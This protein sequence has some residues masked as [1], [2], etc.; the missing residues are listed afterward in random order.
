MENNLEANQGGDENHESAEKMIDAVKISAIFSEEATL[1][2]IAERLL[3]DGSI[4][5]FTIEPVKSGYL[6]KGEK[7]AE[8]QFSLNIL[9][10][11][12]L[13]KGQHIRDEIER[14][15]GDKWD[16]PAIT[17]E[18]VRINEKF[19]TF[20]ERAGVEHKKYVGEKKKKL[21]IALSGLLAIAAALGWIGKKYGDERASEAARVSAKSEKTEAEK[22][23]YKLTEDVRFK[24]VDIERK[25]NEVT[26]LLPQDL[27]K[28]AQ[29]EIFHSA[30]TDMAVA[31]FDETDEI[32]KKMQDLT[33]EMGKLAEK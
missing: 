17:E 21:A 8:G 18:Q 11:G 9:T 6:Y 13:T 32:V 16:V 20:I 31:G 4:S 23:I 30:K 15:I 22:K 10:E 5:G 14:Q 26:E 19:L 12:D 33:L 3:S 24:I 28:R 7:V 2:T 25:I 29:E 1:E 27:K